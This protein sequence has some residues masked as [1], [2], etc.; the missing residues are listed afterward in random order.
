MASFRPASTG[1]SGG[2]DETRTGMFTTNR[3]PVDTSHYLTSSP[4]SPFT[5]TTKTIDIQTDVSE[6]SRHFHVSTSTSTQVSL[7]KCDDSYSN[8]SQPYSCK[9]RLLLQ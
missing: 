8:K 1:G 3:T 4:N 6:L 7:A 2:G 5:P 9:N